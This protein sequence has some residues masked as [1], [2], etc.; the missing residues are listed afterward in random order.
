MNKLRPAA[1]AL[2]QSLS[3]NTL[4]DT[5]D[6]LFP[7]GEI[8]KKVIRDKVDILE[9]DDRFNVGDEEFA[10]AMRRVGNVAP[11]PD[12]I[13]GSILK[14]AAPLIG[15]RLAACYNRC[16]REGNFPSMWKMARLVLLKKPGG[17]DGATS[18]YRPIC[19]LNEMAKLFERIL[20]K[21]IQEHLTH[22]GP[23]L[24]ESQYGF[25]LKRSTIDA[26]LRVREI[27]DRAVSRKKAAIAISFDIKN[28]FNSLPWK[29]ISETMR[30]RNFPK[31]L[32]TIIA[33]YLHKRYLLF[34]G[35]KG[36]KQSR[37]VVCG[38]PQGSVLGPILWDLAYDEILKVR[39]PPGCTLTCYADD[40]VG[41]YW[42][43]HR[44]SRLIGCTWC[45]NIYPCC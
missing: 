1:P 22:H 32:R 28:A 11:G 14:L 29:A 26:I 2:T 30:K 35:P 38:V 13:S 8:K 7:G 43:R 36:A 18:S 17:P 40:P 27:T 37:K 9:W 24:S 16:L 4:K 6:V 3:I 41:R 44:A 34:L 25:R 10:E 5:L 15:W 45:E 20:T 12:G 23:D 21:R 31:Y 33:D 42:L 19:L 39:L